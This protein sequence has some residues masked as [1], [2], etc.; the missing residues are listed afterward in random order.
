MASLSCSV[1]ACGLPHRCIFTAADYVHGFVHVVFFDHVS[2]IVI[3]Y[4]SARLCAHGLHQAVWVLRRPLRATPLRHPDHQ[5][6]RQAAPGSPLRFVQYHLV[7]SVVIPSTPT[8]TS[9]IG[10]FSSPFCARDRRG[11]LLC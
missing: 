10:I 8:I 5:A 7:A 9:C 6:L 3:D 2:D 4:V 1:A 11:G